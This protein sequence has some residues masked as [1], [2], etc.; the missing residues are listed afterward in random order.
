MTLFEL[1]PK[2]CT[3]GQFALLGTTFRAQREACHG[4]IRTHQLRFDLSDVGVFP[5][6]DKSCFTV[7]QAHKAPLEVSI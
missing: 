6:T 3:N 4:I 1:N 2:V 5:S 7:L